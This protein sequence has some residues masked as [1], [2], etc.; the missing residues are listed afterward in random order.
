MTG[1]WQRLNDESVSI[2]AYANQAR[3][4]NA[5]AV[6]EARKHQ[7]IVVSVYPKDSRHRDVPRDK[8]LERL[9]IKFYDSVRANNRPRAK[10]LY[11]MIERRLIRIMQDSLR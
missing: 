9:G 3:S 7:P 4:W 11:L 5:C 10:Q 8:K 6:G 2:S 1:W